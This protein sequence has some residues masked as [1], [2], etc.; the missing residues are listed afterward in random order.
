M[1]AGNTKNKQKLI[2][3]Q[4]VGNQQNNAQ[5]GV[6]FENNNQNESFFNS[7][8][9]NNPNA[10]TYMLNKQNNLQSGVRGSRP[11]VENDQDEDIRD[12]HDSRGQ[13]NNQNEG[14]GTQAKYGQLASKI[15][16]KPDN[17]ARLLIENRIN[18]NEKYDRTVELPETQLEPNLQLI[19]GDII[20]D[21]ALDEY[22]RTLQFFKDEADEEDKKIVYKYANEQVNPIRWDNQ[23]IVHEIFRVV[24][25][26]TLYNLNL[27]SN[28]EEMGRLN[29]LQQNTDINN[30]NKPLS[31]LVQ[32]MPLG[33]K[34]VQFITENANAIHDLNNKEGFTHEIL[35]DQI[36]NKNLSDPPVIR[37]INQQSKLIL[38]LRVEFR[39]L[40][41]TAICKV[42]VS[43]YLDGNIFLNQMQVWSTLPYHKRILRP[44]CFA[45]LNE[46]TPL[47]FVEDMAF[48]NNLEQVIANRSFY[49]G[50][51]YRYE[52][53]HKIL[54]CAIHMTEA[55][56]HAHSNGILHMNL[57]PGNIMVA[58][59]VERDEYPPHIL[60]LIKSAAASKRLEDR[61]EILRLIKQSTNVLLD[62]YCFGVSLL[63]MLTGGYEWTSTIDL[64]ATFESK[65]QKAEV[66]VDSYSLQIFKAILKRC[67]LIQRQDKP[68]DKISDILMNL[69]T[70]K[71]NV[72]RILRENNVHFYNFESNSKPM[73]EFPPGKKKEEL[74]IKDY[75]LYT[76]EDFSQTEQE[77]YNDKNKLHNGDLLGKQ[78]KINQLALLNDPDIIMNEAN[79]KL[80][81]NRIDLE[82][83]RSLYENE[84]VDLITL[85]NQAVLAYLKQNYQQCIDMLFKLYD[86]IETNPISFFNY[87]LLCWEAGIYSDSYLLN[88]INRISTLSPQHNFSSLMYA[89][90]YEAQNNW[91]PAKVNYEIALANASDS[92]IIEIKRRI[93]KCRMFQDKY[94]DQFLF[95]HL[96]MSDVQD[97]VVSFNGKLAITFQKTSRLIVWN[98][99]T[100][101]ILKEIEDK[102]ATC[103]DANAKLDR[104]VV[105]LR[106]GLIVMFNLAF[107]DNNFVANVEEVELGF[108]TSM[109]LV[110]K[111]SKDGYFGMSG[112]MDNYVAL[113]NCINMNGEEFMFSTNSS[114]DIQ[115]YHHYSN[116]KQIQ[117]TFVLQKHKAQVTSL[118]IAYD[119]MLGISGGQDRIIYLWD[120]TSGECL[121]EIQVASFVVR[122]SITSMGKYLSANLLDGSILIYETLTGITWRTE[123]L[124]GKHTG[125]ALV[126]SNFVFEVSKEG[127]EHKLINLLEREKSKLQDEYIEARGGFESTNKSKT[128]KQ[129]NN[130]NQKSS[131]DNTGFKSATTKNKS[132][133]QIEM[134]I[135]QEVEP[136]QESDYRKTQLEDKDQDFKMPEDDPNIHNVN[137]DEELMLQDLF[138]EN[139]IFKYFYF[140]SDEFTRQLN[141]QDVYQ[142]LAGINFDRSK[143]IH[144]QNNYLLKNSLEQ[145][146]AF[147]NLTQQEKAYQIFLL[148]DDR[149]YKF[150]LNLYR[151]PKN[152]LNIIKNYDHCKLIL[153]AAET[154]AGDN[155]DI[156]HQGQVVGLRVQNTNLPFLGV[157][158]CQLITNA[159]LTKN[160]QIKIKQKAR[161]MKEQALESYRQKSEEQS[162]YYMQ[163]LREVQPLYMNPSVVKLWARM[164]MNSYKKGKIYNIF[165]IQQLN[166]LKNHNNQIE[167]MIFTKNERTL[168][169]MSSDFK[170]TLWEV[171]DWNIKRQFRA[172]HDAHARF[173]LKNMRED[174]IV[175]E[176]DISVVIINDSC[177]IMVCGLYNGAIQFWDLDNNKEQLQLE[178]PSHLAEVTALVFNSDQSMLVS[179]G[180]DYLINVWSAM[181]K[182]LLFEIREH[183]GSI[184][185][186]AF[187]EEQ[188][189]E[190]QTEEQIVSVDVEGYMIYVTLD[191]YIEKKFSVERSSS[192]AI[193]G[194]DVVFS[195]Y[196]VEREIFLVRRNLNT[197]FFE[198]QKIK[199]G[200]EPYYAAYDCNTFPTIIKNK[201]DKRRGNKNGIYVIL[202]QGVISQTSIKEVSLSAWL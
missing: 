82:R 61:R 46:K 117:Q 54:S 166:L 25:D 128:Q 77:I 195:S 145:V 95:G 187:V 116:K 12:I 16:Q 122:L 106:N 108:H 75:E 85:N 14:K 51:S 152:E 171:G 18:K 7:N 34:P 170:V 3:Q 109:I 153:L 119:G 140:Q 64:Q 159:D 112:G 190:G 23:T 67:L 76:S 111:L 45:S 114:F 65:M 143:D 123:K 197:S 102:N 141:P 104:I 8:D 157:G 5:N 162:K 57:H 191:G 36:A 27:T 50:Y 26:L 167:H 62:I 97:I 39:K 178:I 130:Q 4:V 194:M 176:F 151:S 56:N 84:D 137:Q 48:C 134:Q 124:Y 147:Q 115:V 93:E 177:T 89:I 96:E 38:T 107:E 148:L 13:R 142:E 30:P 94:P 149:R 68:F 80:N 33:L 99:Q 168:L 24:Q 193:E 22:L 58:R 98:L 150:D 144:Q 28:G 55:L 184:T 164:Q 90:L 81:R 120:L 189:E 188:N 173:Y 138:F 110:V 29:D 83:P 202:I 105:G 47:V 129:S 161:Q 125:I 86:I 199:A 135:V 20:E 200:V 100:Q 79:K 91:F 1:G 66:I 21:P 103:M 63:F 53:A 31:E 60:S 127:C 174:Q 32:Q 132:Q 179:A 15:R 160:I 163:R 169:I 139:S 156:T 180:A 118:E 185:Y 11:Q 44:I 41:R 131:N 192:H 198:F 121:R 158:P 88:E 92:T 133:T 9:P 19:Y 87:L 154:R 126:A 78:T 2:A 155:S 113:W 49:R 186:L 183:L 35:Y 40:L 17:E 73:Y 101:K 201:V 71:T 52:L 136:D 72:E 172:Y 6:Q 37:Q 146:R 10:R 182:S 196:V 43:E 74:L 165:K 181:S 42:P 70:A 59:C 175:D 69:H